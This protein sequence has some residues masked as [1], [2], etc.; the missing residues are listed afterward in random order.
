MEQLISIVVPIYNA[1]STLDKCIQSLRNQTYEKIEIILIN[2]G[3]RDRSLEI[4][5]NHE[6]EDK[7]IRVIDKKNG[8]VSSA[9]NA[10]LTIASGKFVMFCDSDD[11]AEPEWCEELVTHYEENCL[12]MCAHYVEGVQTY[13][14]HEIKATGENV[15]LERSQFYKLKLCNFN[16]PWNKIFDM[17]IIQ[18]YHLKF[19]D[20]ITNGEDYLFI[21]QYLEK[22][23]GNILFLKKCVFHYL[24]PRE[25]SLSSKISDDYLEQC[26]FLFNNILR[27]SEKI[28]LKD[29]IG[30]KQ[31]MTDFYNEFQKILISVLNDSNISLKQRLIKMSE[32]MST[33]E[34]QECA[35]V[36]FISPNKVY[37]LLA[38]Q[39]KGIG[40]WIWHKLRN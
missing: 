3:S 19:D 10:G 32:I 17:S 16:A 11:W 18:K 20:K 29:D 39:K 27:L 35:S 25:Y 21:M 1:E 13:I 15:C 37:S 8:G 36:A 14:P 9:R 12:I 5:R 4:C 40:L 24:W 28:G 31:I 30:K 34:Y 33:N 6:N 22:I 26:C 38:R 23:D 2:D 7:R